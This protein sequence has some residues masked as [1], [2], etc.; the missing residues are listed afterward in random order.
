VRVSGDETASA[1]GAIN[2]AHASQSASPTAVVWCRQV[3]N[4]AES[5][6]YTTV[7]DDFAGRSATL[8][9]IRLVGNLT[10]NVADTHDYWDPDPSAPLGYYPNLFLYPANGGRYTCLGRMFLSTEDRPRLGMKTLVLDT[11]SLLDTGEFGATLLRWYAS[12]GAA[13]RNASPPPIPDPAL[14]GLLGEGFLFHR[15]STEPVVAVASDLWEPSVHAIFDLIRLLP[16]SLISL[17]AIL[18]FP[19]FLPQPKTNLHEFTEQVPLSLALMRVPKQEARGERHEKR[20]AS[21]EASNVTF[22]DLTDGI[23]AASG[24]AKDATPLVLQYVRDHQDAKLAPIARRVDLVELPRLRSHLA[25]PERQGGK[26]RRKE[27]WRIGTAMESAALLLQKARGRHV[28]V[29]LETAK[30][31]QSYLQA[32]LP[33][34]SA[35]ARSGAEEPAVVAVPAAASAA[36]AAPGS[37]DG[38]AT[39][40]PPWLKRA[41]ELPTAPTARASRSETVPLSVSDDPSLFPSNGSGTTRDPPVA[42]SDPSAEPGAGRTASL[43]PTPSPSFSGQ[44]PGAPSPPSPSMARPP[45]GAPASVPG[46]LSGPTVP[47]PTALPPPP[48]A[49]VEGP[50]GPGSAASRPAPASASDNAAWRREFESD[51][52]RFVEERLTAFRESVVVRASAAAEGETKGKLEALIDEKLR[53]GLSAN[54]PTGSALE[55]QIRDRLAAAQQEWTA[56]SAGQ[57]AQLKAEWDARLKEAREA[58]QRSVDESV[59]KAVELSQSAESRQ[60]EQF[61]A[62]L[63]ASETRLQQ[64]LV[65]IVQAELDKRLKAALD[66][67]VAEM[68]AKGEKT[69]KLLGE[70]LAQQLKGEFARAVDETKLRSN[71][72]EEGLREGLSAQMDLHLQDAQDRQEEM[73][74]ETTKA[75]AES[76]DK[77]FA[78]LDARRAKE[79]R[80]SEGRIAAA[81]EARSRES[82]EKLG[83]LAQELQAKVSRSV[84]DRLASL[85]AKTDG[86]L[87]TRLREMASSQVHA[88]A[89]L[90]VGLQSYT[91]QK[92]RESLEAERVEAHDEIAGLQREVS[93]VLAHAIDSAQLDTIL[94]D[95]FARLGETMRAEHARSID[96]RISVA[97]EHLAAELAEATTKIETADRSIA[98]QTRELEA[99]EDSIRVELDEFDRRLVVLSDRLIP[100]VRKTWLRIAELE[101]GAA[102][103]SESELQ[104]A[105]IRRE[106]THEVRRLESTF[107]ERTTELRD[108]METAIANQGKVWLTLVRQL[109]QLTENRRAQA[110][111]AAAPEPIPEAAPPPAPADPDDDEAL[112]GLPAL[113][114]SRS[115]RTRVPAVN[116]LDP[117]DDESG[118]PASSAPERDPLAELEA[119]REPPR[120]RLRRSSGRS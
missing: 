104:I 81:L 96:Q 61:A 82:A 17:G 59:R 53:A 70:T 52:R 94:K 97:E 118:P 14:Y 13:R 35:A 39:L 19:Y 26:D 110:E 72:I 2:A 54:G 1:P 3:D 22:R 57:V 105:S 87:E 20:L 90:Q 29:N 33:S 41:A 111:A 50:A 91:D 74:R 78:E 117:E 12:M 60:N 42:P 109:S 43:G 49:R 56:A 9:V 28:P 100:V 80:E 113:M 84:D 106:I 112:V 73:Q 30:R 85:E 64:G 83:Q 101:K 103:P 31:A 34:P 75:F 115:A 5:P 102:S 18:A 36:P 6:G 10:V 108:R 89:E 15:G 32:Q 46:T 98:E 88:V 76:L 48:P 27:M 62:R 116:P 86:K 93:T 55:A 16:A 107:S 58:F 68:T 38:V 7:P 51:L 92:V 47:L 45:A 79:V 71:A 40:L 25:D 8:D 77:R 24:R 11:S 95:R 63:T 99:L 4:E 23:P 120:R 21:W 69:L 67:Q 65:P 66:G 37:I 114:R 44:V 119:T